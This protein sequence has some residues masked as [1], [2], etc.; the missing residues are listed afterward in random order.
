MSKEYE[1]ICSL[2]LDGINDANSTSVEI[3]DTP[4]EDTVH[5]DEEVDGLFSLLPQEYGIFIST[6]SKDDIEI[7][8]QEINRPSSPLLLAIRGAVDS[9]NQYDDFDILNKI[10]SGFFADVFKVRFKGSWGCM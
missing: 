6:P 5:S 10:G 2:P 1:K 3:Y 4:S 8:H 7:E 9:L